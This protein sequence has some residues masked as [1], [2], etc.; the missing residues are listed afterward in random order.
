METYN[1][2]VKHWVEIVA[3]YTGLVTIASIIVKW[4]KTLK[5]DNIVL[6]IIKIL[7]KIALNRNI[8]DKALRDKDMVID[9]ME[10]LNG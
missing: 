2:I 6:P 5:D 7:A 9:E 1:F 10:H 3:I 8:D 4:T